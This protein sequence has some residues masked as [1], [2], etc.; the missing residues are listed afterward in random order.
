MNRHTHRQSHIQTFWL[1][2][3]IC[4]EG[5]CFEKKERRKKHVTCD[6][7][8]VTSN[9]WHMTCV[10]LWGVNNFSRFQLP[11]SNGLWFMIFWRFGGKGSPNDWLTDSINDKGV[12]RTPPATPGHPVTWGVG[13]DDLGVATQI[14]FLHQFYELCNRTEAPEVCG[15][16]QGWLLYP[17]RKVHLWQNILQ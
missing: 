6:M 13:R 15:K 1:I 5:R 17:P 2:E 8:Q 14:R 16:P 12:C 4:P 9:T 3:S 11:S 10:M 7:W